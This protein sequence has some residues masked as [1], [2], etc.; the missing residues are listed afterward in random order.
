[1]PTSVNRPRDV[2][3][4]VMGGAS[5]DVPEG[6]ICAKPA[7]TAGGLSSGANENVAPSGSGH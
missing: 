4:T 2:A 7:A 1:M 3:V 5:A 6:S